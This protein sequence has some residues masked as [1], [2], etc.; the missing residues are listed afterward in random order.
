MLVLLLSQTLCS[1]TSTM[2][3]FAIMMS[4][5]GESS[6]VH[7]LS[8]IYIATAIPALFIT[9]PCGVLIDRF[10]KRINLLSAD[11]LIALAIGA[12]F[13]LA[14]LKLSWLMFAVVLLIQIGISYQ[15]LTNQALIAHYF[16]KNELHIINGLLQFKKG[17]QKLVAPALGGYLY[18]ITSV[19]NILLL[20]GLSISCA[21]LCLALIKI[22]PLKDHKLNQQRFRLGDGFRCLMDQK[23]LKRLAGLFF[24]INFLAGI[25]SVVYTPVLLE[26]A[27]EKVL[28]L[29]LST[30]SLGVIMGSFMSMRFEL[31]QPKKLLF[32]LIALN[33][34]S[35]M[36][37]SYPSFWLFSL[38]LFLSSVCSSLIAI[39]NQ[40]MWQS[41]VPPHLQGRVFGA[42]DFIAMSS[43]PLGMLAGGFLGDWAKISL[44]LWSVLCLTGVVQ[45][46]MGAFFYLAYKKRPQ[47]MEL[48]Q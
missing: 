27:D 43:L 11:L 14:D 46:G 42:R 19:S 31:N 48:A 2:V 12:L 37:T 3:I 34:F 9:V 6:S 30:G 25:Y 20:H 18:S 35:E 39:N 26:F 23:E 32:L 33:G 17:F 8:W 22:P 36:V 13:L 38:G 16:G 5:Y 45:I 7:S 21:L 40:I 10:S 28:G 1:I 4:A 24:Q 41:A 15:G 29:A 44:G 47:K